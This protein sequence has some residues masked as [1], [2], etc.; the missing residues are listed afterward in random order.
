MHNALLLVGIVARDNSKG[1]FRGVEVDGLM[2]H[3]RFDQDEISFLAD[4]RFLQLLTVARSHS[5]FEQIMAVS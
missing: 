1:G 2:R 5:A 3:V 4:D